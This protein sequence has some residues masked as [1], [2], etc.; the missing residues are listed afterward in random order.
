MKDYYK[1]LEVNENSTIEEIKK[2][3]RILS[4]K[5]HPDVNP[6]GTEKFKEISEAYDVLSD[7][8]KRSQYDNSKRNPFQNGMGF[9]DI[10]SQ[11]FNN[12]PFHQQRRK[13]SPDKVVKV[14]ITP[15]ESFL[16]SEKTIQY[17]KENHCDICSGTGGDQQACG[18]CGGQG[19]HVKTFG[20]GFMVQ[21]VRTTCPTCAGRGYTLIHKCHSCNGNG[22]KSGVSTVN[23][24]LPHGIDSG[25]YIRL[26][27]LGDFKNGDYGDLIIQVEVINKDGFEKMNNELV[28]NLYLDFDSLK[29]EKYNIP[30]PKGQISVDAPAVFDTSRPLRIKGMGYNGADMYVKLNVKFKR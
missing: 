7:T 11:M 18:S 30:H 26:E 27:N 2:N 20:T 10:F 6:D 9:D 21:H 15:V 5:Y 25:Q 4:K 8:N 3:Y 1:I 28:Y 19:F 13:Q 16:S 22:V 17:V 14:Q 24:K 29:N 12:S 23:V